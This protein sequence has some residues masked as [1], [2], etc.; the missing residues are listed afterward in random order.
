MAASRYR[1]KHLVSLRKYVATVGVVAICALLG[2]VTRT[3]GLATPNIAMIFFAGVVLVAVR[4]GHRPAVLAA[5]LGVLVFDYLFVEPLF[6]FAP[7]DAQYV[8]EFAVMLGTGLLIS[9]LTARLEAQL[10][11]AQQQER[12]TA[13]LY[14]LT[15]RLNDLAGSD[16][17]VANAAGQ[18]AET[19]DGDVLIYLRQPS[20]EVQLQHGNEDSVGR[21]PVNA[22]AAKCAA[23]TNGP[24]G[25]GTKTYPGATALFV[26]MIGAERTIGAL[27][28]R[29]HDAVRFL[30]AHEP[31]MLETCANL[32]ALSIGRDES[33]AEA[34]RAQIQAETERLRSA[35]LSSVSHDL[36]TP[37]ATI[38]VTASSLLDGNGEQNWAAKRE[39]LETVVDESHRL[40]HQVDNLL[41][42][43]R[44]DAGG[45]VLDRDGQ[46]VEELVGV[47]LSRM[48]H[49]LRGRQVVARIPDS[50]PL[51]WATSELIEQVLVNIL[52][53]AIR[54]TPAHTAIE[55]TATQRGEQVEICISDYGPGLPSGRESQIFEK[56]FRGKSVVADGQRGVGLGLAI[57]R[58]IVRAHGGEITATNRSQG[59]AEFLVMLPC[60]V[61]SSEVTLE[62]FLSP[63]D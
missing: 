23:E 34:Q 9:E 52:E 28:V 40:G 33:R 24:T 63:T 26:P 20:G 47:A 27:G 53:N 55:I 54:Y 31:R 38:A 2:W 57:C 18:L 36:R 42:M 43:A 22:L 50:L 39:I 6:R 44:L 14:E 3:A 11:T 41:D 13:R 15:R 10:R 1:I 35:L 4:G 56:F 21:V 62:E 16:H 59:G 45:I 48:R 8:V 29:P 19:F 7:S 46:V 49:E 58:S 30:D 37:L 17:L 5:V 61:Q 51:V 32:L 25:L 12:R 60:A